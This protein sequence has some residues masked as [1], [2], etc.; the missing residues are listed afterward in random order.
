M[1]EDKQAYS[2]VPFI[3]KQHF[4]ACGKYHDATLDDDAENIVEELHKK[5]DEVIGSDYRT[6][7]LAAVCGTPERPLYAS[8]LIASVLGGANGKTN[9]RSMSLNRENNPRSE[10]I[11]RSRSIM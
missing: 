3:V 1:E 2:S 11:P 6:K 7:I 10:R 4:M 9:A 5:C 8:R